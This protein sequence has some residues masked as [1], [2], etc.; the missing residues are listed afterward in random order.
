MSNGSRA[1]LACGAAPMAA[2]LVCDVDPMATMN[3]KSEQ[4]QWG[5]ERT[6]SGEG[7]GDMSGG[8]GA[9]LETQIVEIDSAESG[10]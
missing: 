9:A 1:V 8:E 5:G 2:F 10:C 6:S 7:G 4:Q 3:R